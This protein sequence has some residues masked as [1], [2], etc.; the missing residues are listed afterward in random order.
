M[1]S[2]THFSAH[3]ALLAPI[4]MTLALYYTSPNTAHLCAVFPGRG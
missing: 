4:A 2:S 1:N 3:E